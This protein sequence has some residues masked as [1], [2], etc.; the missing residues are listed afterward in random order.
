MRPRILLASLCLGLLLI[1]ARGSTHISFTKSVYYLAMG[2]SV[3]AGQ[4]LGRV[5]NS[6]NSS[7]PHLHIHAVRAGTGSALDGEAVALTF[8]GRFPV[9]GSI[10]RS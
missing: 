3:A 7:E 10:I 9:R 6:G 2:D 4:A 1:L 5:G 8:G